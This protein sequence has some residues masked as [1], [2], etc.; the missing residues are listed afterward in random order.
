MLRYVN[1]GRWRLQRPH[2]QNSTVYKVCRRADAL[3]AGN[4]TGAQFAAGGVTV[5]GSEPLSQ[6]LGVAA[7][8]RGDLA[9]RVKRAALA[10]GRIPAA[11]VGMFGDRRVGRR[12]VGSP[13][14][15]HCLCAI[16][17]VRRFP[18]HGQ[19]RRLQRHAC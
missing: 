17:P 1:A 13:G 18:G 14:R 3:R 11:M 8:T 2:F 9:S 12:L 16:Q 4:P 7:P 10:V 6:V 15:R 19:P 5:N